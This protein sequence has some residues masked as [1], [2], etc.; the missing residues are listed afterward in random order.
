[1]KSIFEVERRKDFET[2]YNRFFGMLDETELT[3]VPDGVY[4]MADYMDYCI[5]YWPYRC[6]TDNIKDYLADI[7][8]DSSYIE[9]DEER[10]LVLELYLNLLYWAPHQYKLDCQRTTFGALNMSNE[11]ADESQRLITNLEYIL[12]QCCNM[13]VREEKGKGVVKYCIS[14]RD[15]VVDAAVV[16]VPEL[17]S[18][19]L[20]YLD[21]RNKNDISYKKRA[22]EVMY[23]YME[24]HRNEYKGL[25][26][27]PVSEE[28]FAC[29]NSLGIRH[30]TE[31]QRAIPNAKR[32]S[33][34]DKLFEMAL[35][36]L[37]TKATNQACK[38]MRLIRTDFESKAK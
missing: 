27:Q 7:N 4:T 24:P 8:I 31:N 28:F 3:D 32:I 36:V 5:R 23:K 35:Y 10:Y 37:Q 12:E 34:Y 30:N 29:M 15:P 18:V 26:C 33:V 13:R 11:I 19:L 14:K 1:M 17:S 9:T 20:G 21:I 25:I 2:G 16:C 38:E 6:G 22:L